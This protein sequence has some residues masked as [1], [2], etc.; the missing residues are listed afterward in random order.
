MRSAEMVT[1]VE[2]QRMQKGQNKVKIVRW[3]AQTRK[4]EP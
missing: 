3:P 4:E 1:L 2:M